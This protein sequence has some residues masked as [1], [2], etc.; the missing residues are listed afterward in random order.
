MEEQTTEITDK[1]CCCCKKEEDNILCCK[2]CDFCT[3]MDCMS[4]DFTCDK[5]NTGGES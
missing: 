1:K 5:C 3:C 2:R 4:T